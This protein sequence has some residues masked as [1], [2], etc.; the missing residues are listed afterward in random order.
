M[1]NGD[2][3]GKSVA[4]IGDLDSDGVTDLAVGA[5]LDDTGG[6]SNG[7][8]YILF[9]NANGTAK[10]TTKIA[11]STNGGST[12]IG[13]FFGTSV[14]AIGDLNSDGITDLA[15]GA[16]GDSTGGLGR[17]AVH[18]LLMNPSG[19]VQSSV[20]IASGANGGPAL[21][22]ND[23][24][25]NSIANLGDLDGDGVVDIVVGAGADDTG[26]ANRGA[27]HVLFLNSD[28]TAKSTAKIASGT[29]GG[30]TLA[31]TDVFG[32]SVANVGDLNGD[33][34]TD[35]AVGAKFDDTGGAGTNRGALYLLNLNAA[36][37]AVSSSK[38][39]NALNGGP[40]IGVG[41]AF[42]VSVA[43][44]GDIDGDGAADLIV[45]GYNESTGGSQRGAVH[46]LQL[47]ALNHAPTALNLSSNSVAENAVSGT[48]VG[49]LSGVDQDVPTTFT[50]SLVSGS[51]ST[52]NASF[53]IT[54][55]SLKTNAV[56][57]FETKST[58]EIRI[59]A[60]DQGGL[61]TEQSI[62][63]T[64]TNTNDAPVLDNSGNPFA[65]LGVGSR[66]S[67]EM[68]QGVLVS[69]IPAARGSPTP[70]PTRTPAPPSASR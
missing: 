55:N 34:V 12:Q 41:E 33:G 47:G 42:G 36:G 18:V 3:F 68:R 56:F 29:G 27:V 19:T 69:D 23:N 9:L 13:G 44:L 57:D 59:R 50:F 58:F 15:V 26:G 62:P 63:I 30:P 38:I 32:I 28:G 20:R 1:V 37:T 24:L 7:A 46:L 6:A 52:D 21:A 8:V 64:V 2:G 17:G 67:L 35:I 31:N 48:T 14:T 70:S 39:A 4:N 65:I 22:D 10:S 40:L 25:G 54:G 49:T 16:T 11:R 51:G 5:D 60:T 53:T 61:F 45:G 43:N 66:Q